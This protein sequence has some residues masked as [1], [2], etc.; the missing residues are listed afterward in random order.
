M[1]QIAPIQPN[2]TPP[3]P[4]GGSPPPGGEQ[5]AFSPHLQKALNDRTGRNSGD[6][7]SDNSLKALNDRTGRNGGDNSSDNSLNST[8]PDQ[9]RHRLIEETIA[10]QVSNQFD[11]SPIQTEKEVNQ[12]LISRVAA[13]IDSAIPSIAHQL[14]T[15]IGVTPAQILTSRQ[16]TFSQEISSAL[17]SQ[18]SDG[19]GK[20]I[21]STV[22][23]QGSMPQAGVFPQVADT[24]AMFRFTDAKT[25]GH[26]AN[27]GSLASLAFAPGSEAQ[28]L[29]G[30]EGKSPNH[31]DTMLGQLQHIIANS[32]ETG[33][34]AINASQQSSAYSEATASS[35]LSTVA[36]FIGLNSSVIKPFG[37]TTEK[38][39]HQLSGLR[40]NIH[41]QYYEAKIGQFSS[42]NAGAEENQA[43][44]EAGRQTASLAAASTPASM[45]TVADSGITFHQTLVTGQEPAPL[46]ATET[47]RAIPLPG[48]T[49]VHDQQV[50]QQVIERFQLNKRPLETH[51]NIRLHPAELGALKIDLTVSEGSI[52]A[53]VVVQNQQVQEIIERNLARLRSIL[54]GQGFTIDSL[55]VTSES[56]TV[57]EF[58]HFD[59]RPFQHGTAPGG[60]KASGKPAA[61][62]VDF[63]QLVAGDTKE[64]Q[65]VNLKI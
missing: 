39:G 16:S 44:N 27:Q 42:Q 35:S 10:T 29:T 4:P 63:D 23:A 61:S 59:S 20:P 21:L 25:G 1:A 55:V 17:W 18:A 36:Q 3:P 46:M 62:T 64:N 9:S 65:V 14:E 11:H 8:T 53:S 5:Q 22:F 49:Q 50:M 32:S 41:Q 28:P 48:A 24:D 7:S 31:R 58:N 47:G 19:L 60:L 37:T 38:P 45:A 34:V 43:Q 13:E 26:P 52:R 51:I 6:N 30:G 56:E 54:E 2:L 40:Q 15:N 57:D 12:D 33:R